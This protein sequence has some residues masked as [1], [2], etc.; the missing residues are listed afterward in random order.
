MPN[1]AVL[2]AERRPCRHL[3]WPSACRRTRCRC[4]PSRSAAAAERITSG[5]RPFWLGA[6]GRSYA[7][8]LMS[9]LGKWNESYLI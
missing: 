9:S 6:R 3:S 4:Y 7:K 2:G 5:S 1:G 8:E